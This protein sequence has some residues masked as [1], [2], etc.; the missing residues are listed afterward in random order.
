M[1]SK[2]L[3]LL[4]CCAAILFSGCGGGDVGGNVGKVS[5]SAAYAGAESGDYM[6]CISALE[7]GLNVNKG[8]ND[9][10]TLLHHAT[11]GNQA[12]IVTNLIEDYKADVN[13]KDKSG[14]TPLAYAQ[15]SQ[16]EGIASVLRTAGAKE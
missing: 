14:K 16:N 8:D 12:K 5:V 9:G 6:A 7:N 11:I 1:Y 2:C 13:V 4:G 10:K 3:A 15:E